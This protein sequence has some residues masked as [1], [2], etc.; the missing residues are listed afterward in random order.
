MARLD[1]QQRKKAHAYLIAQE[2]EVLKKKEEKQKLKQSKTPTS[3][4]VVMKK[5]VVRERRIDKLARKKRERRQ[6]KGPAR[7][8][9]DGDVDMDKRT[10]KKVKRT[11]RK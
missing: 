2:L 8:V 6:R 5:E 11:I 4:D 1:K 9:N 3:K 10:S 7:V